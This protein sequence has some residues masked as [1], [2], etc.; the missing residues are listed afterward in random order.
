MTSDL[1]TALVL[2]IV[3]MLS[4]FTVLAILVMCARLLIKITNQWVT[5][6]ETSKSTARKRT[7]DLKKSNEQ[8]VMVAILS[9]VELITNGKGR[10][11]HIEKM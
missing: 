8:E 7:K 2:L 3:G 10:V 11:T 9:T 6:E 1:S 4:V 5:E